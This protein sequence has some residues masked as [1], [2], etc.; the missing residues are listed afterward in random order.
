MRRVLALVTVLAATLV[1]LVAVT[2][3]PAPA[4][5]VVPQ[6]RLPS[7]N[8][9]NF[10]P[11]VLDGEVDAIAQVGDWIVLGGNFTQ[12]QAA[13]GGP[14]LTRNSILAFHKSTGAIS[15]AFAP[16]MSGPVKALATGPN[17]T[18][19]AGGSFNSVGA[20]NAYKVAQ[21][22]ISDGGVVSA[23][24][25][26]VVNAIVQDVRYT[27]GRLFIGGQFPRGANTT[28]LSLAELNPS[29]GAVLPL[30]VPVEGTHFGGQ[31]QIYHMDVNPDGT[32]LAMIGNFTTVGGQT[33]VEA[34]MVDLTTNT[35]SSWHTSRFEP[36][37]YSVFKF[38]VRD[39]EFSPDGQYFVIATTGGF[40]SGSPTLCDTVTRW[41]SDATGPG[42]NPT[43]INYTGGDSNY[44]AVPTGGAIYIGGHERWVNNPSRG[45][46]EGPGA[47]ARQGIAALDPLNGLPF[48]WN[49]GRVR[50]QGVFDMLATTE[51][52]FIGS[53]TDQVHGEYHGKVAFFPLAGGSPIPVFSPPTLPVRL[54][55]LGDLS[56]AATNVLY[57][58]NAGGGTVA[59]LDAGPDWA[60]DNGDPSPVRNS[61][62]NAAGWS[63]VSAVNGTVPAS[64]PSAIFDTERWD[65]SGGDEMRWSF[66]VAAGKQI[67]VRL[68]LA[69]RC[70]CTSGAGLRKFDVS[71][72]G[73]L[74]LDDYDVFADAGDQTGTM[75]S[76]DI[77][78]DGAVDI[79]FSHVVENP[80]VNGIEIIDRDATPPSAG[81][82]VVSR[83]YNGSTVGAATAVPGGG[84]DWSQVRGSFMA[85]S[86]LY[87]AW[88]D[89]HLYKRSFD[90]S[91]FGAPTD[92]NL[93]GLTNFASEMRN[94]TGLFYDNGRIYYTMTGSS[95]LH[96]RYFTV[97]SDT[98]G[99]GLRDLQP[100]TVADSLPDV[101]W[102][103]VRGLVLIGDRLYWAERSTG[104]LHRVSWENGK[105]VAGTDTVVS[106]PGIDGVRW[107]QRSLLA[108]QAA[109]DQLPVARFTETC[110]ELSCRFDASTSSDKEGPVSYSW[111][112]GD[113]T[114]S[115]QAVVDHDYATAKTYQVSLTVTD[116]DG[117]I[118]SVSRA[119]T[120]QE[121]PNADPV[122]DFTWSC[123]Q[124]DCQFTSTSHDD[125]GA[126]VAHAWD[127]GSA[128]TST[129]PTPQRTLPTGTTQVSLTVT[130]DEGATG[131][132]S[133][134]VTVADSAVSHVG[135]SADTDG[136]SIR[137]H[138]VAVPGGVQPGDRLVL[139]FNDNAPN[140]AVTPPGGWTQ[141]GATTTSGMLSRIWT[142]TATSADVG[143]TVTVS[144]ASPARA[145]LS[146]S[147][148]RDTAPIAPADVSVAAETVNR[149]DHTTP[150]V[151][152]DVA[153][154][155]VVSMW[156]DK[157]AATTTWTPPAGQ[158]VRTLMAESGTGH[159]T[160]LITDSGGVVPVGVGG[161]LTATADSVSRQAVMATLVLRP[162]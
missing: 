93:N 19:Y 121:T 28:R 51:G 53:D 5:Q 9:S 84:V 154:A 70:T 29:T 44:T 91:S 21:L 61:G 114:T 92:I 103:N 77:T 37:C 59:S 64:T 131:T 110:A 115:T 49:P 106:G 50:G 62:S 119:V 23:F 15:T 159:T 34:A 24:K 73:Q 160:Q 81:D 99:A 105:P 89:G 55:S 27:A 125:D 12:V 95:R 145:T 138:T 6:D 47:V 72:D 162:G 76:W 2:A 130:D 101:A 46:A 137:N 122:A 83:K 128:G 135:S 38:I 133:K 1:G 144:T 94:M 14:V 79:L 141:V 155:W 10:T 143:S 32:K 26:G 54:Y 148:Y 18:V 161:G 78:S 56:S 149:A 75:K 150:T 31:T 33:R 3:A 109:A 86:T 36:Q 40:G 17:G 111:D 140:L 39:V 11:H 22:R 132:V 147:A 66:P 97:E 69:N 156:S 139:Y 123:E 108:L 136:G 65:P 90:G 74:R 58:L 129:D 41:E 118:D 20:T 45:D 124:R 80:L 42:Q 127:F 151:D 43:W 57:R 63:P 87:T 13:S 98:V 104:N 116:S 68:Y 60:S 152:V 25:P 113:G 158:A 146:M 153:G 16:S 120:V 100:F 117:Q 7:D 142:R 8:P 134:A 107:A 82:G 102:G 157:T 48:S 67:Q 112:L 71:I 96:M 88:A 4:L 85:G 35:V 30:D 126:V 52:L